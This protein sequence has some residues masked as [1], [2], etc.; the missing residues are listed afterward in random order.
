MMNQVDMRKEAGELNGREV[1]LASDEESMMQTPAP[2][3]NGS[4]RVADTSAE[5]PTSSSGK[6]KRV[7]APTSFPR[8]FSTIW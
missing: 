3:Q 2:S 7:S 5:I 4:I 1:S 6:E 8:N